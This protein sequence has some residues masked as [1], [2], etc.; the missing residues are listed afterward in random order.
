MHTVV[1]L[2]RNA[3]SV[4]K[5]VQPVSVEHLMGVTMANVTN[6]NNTKYYSQSLWYLNLLPILLLLLYITLFGIS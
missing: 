4:A 2:N 1:Q 6:K 3:T 5:H